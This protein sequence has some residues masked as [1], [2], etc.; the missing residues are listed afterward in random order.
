MKYLLIIYFLFIGHQATSATTFVTPAKDKLPLE[1]VVL[2]ESLNELKLT[3]N[4]QNQYIDEAKTLNGFLKFLTKEQI[5]FLVKAQIYKNVLEKEF[6]GDYKITKFTSLD[7]EAIEKNYKANKNS[8]SPYASW[9]IQS[10]LSD[11]STLKNY[12]GFN[13]VKL[14]IVDK[15]PTLNLI[16]KKLN[17]LSP[18]L[19]AIATLTAQDFNGRLKKM[20]FKTLADVK[21]GAYLLKTYP[22]RPAETTED[23]ILVSLKPQKTALPLK[24]EKLPTENE[25]SENKDTESLTD[26]AEMEQK[27][28][29]EAVENLKIDEN[30]TPPAFATPKWEPKEEKAEKTEDSS[31]KIP[32]ASDTWKPEE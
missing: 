23:L 17:L 16:R 8:Y 1:L 7:I 13:Q 10:V 3:P 15:D 21:D 24:E 4:E 19:G 26:S 9:L 28:A 6:Q 14:S 20:M 27:K 11:F 32:P 2:L 18:W 25:N 12:P 30:V 5:Y 29:Q 31:Q 22:T